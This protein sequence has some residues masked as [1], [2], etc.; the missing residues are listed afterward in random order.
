MYQDPLCGAFQAMLRGD[1]NAGSD[2]PIYKHFLVWA[3]DKL[4]SIGSYL[5]VNSEI[6]C[7][8]EMATLPEERQKGYG[9]IM[10]EK[11]VFDAMNEHN[12]KQI[13]LHGTDMGQPLYSSFGFVKTCDIPVFGR[14]AS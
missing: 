3:N 12:A 14:M 5:M 13:I 10:L 1:T 6:A 7:I 8:F 11:L 9:A 2:G 4:V